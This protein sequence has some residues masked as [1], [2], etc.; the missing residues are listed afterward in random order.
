MTTLSFDIIQSTNQSFY[1]RVQDLGLS[2][3]PNDFCE[4]LPYFLRLKRLVLRIP[5]SRECIELRKQ[6][7]TILENFFHCL[8]ASPEGLCA[9][10]Q[11]L[12]LIDIMRS[13]GREIII[14]EDER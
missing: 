3:R 10:N 12:E 2:I 1:L 7:L 9:R 5:S 13:P 6:V 11:V 8:S 14:V 4:E